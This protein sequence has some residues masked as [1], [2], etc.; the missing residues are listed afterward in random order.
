MWQA[1]SRDKIKLFVSISS[2]FSINQYSHFPFLDLNY[3]KT[4]IPK[5]NNQA[6][7]A[8]WP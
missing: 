5:S 1:I 7:L 6:L 4:K 2:G 3:H 8:I